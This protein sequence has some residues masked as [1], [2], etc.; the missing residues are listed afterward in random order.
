MDLSN[1]NVIHIKEDG[2][3]YLQ[4]RRLLEYKDSIAHAFTLGINNDFRMPLYDSNPKKLTKEQIEQNKNNYK[5]ICQCIGVEYNNIVKTNQVH[6]DIIKNVNGKINKY[7]PDFHEEAYKETD[8]LMTNQKNLAICATNA[9]CIVLMMYDKVKKVI[10][11]VHSGWRGTIQ[12]IGAKTIDKMQELYNCNPKDIICCISPSIRSCHF[13]VSEDVKEIFNK[14]FINNDDIIKKHNDKW[15]IDTV[16]LNI[17]MLK[18][19]G[20]RE[21]N[22]IDSKICTVCNSNLIHS[23]RGSNKTNGLEM[24]IIELK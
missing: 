18:E 15:H 13:E 12:R 23:Y 11:N 22:I 20:L 9:D 16:K 5:K 2:I 24:G 17:D 19:K 8:G 1:E 10:A 21:E 7:M 6:K 3:E 4:F 14:T